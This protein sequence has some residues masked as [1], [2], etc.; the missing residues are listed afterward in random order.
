[1]QKALFIVFLLCAGS[2]PVAAVPPDNASCLECHGDKGMTASG[3]DGKERSLFVDQ[4]AFGKSVH[5]GMSCTDCHADLQSL[6]EYPHQDKLAKADCS[7]CH[8]TVT[9]EYNRSMHAGVVRLGRTNAPSCASCHTAHQITPASD[10]ASPTHKTKLAMLCGTC[11][12]KSSPGPNDVR[13]PEVYAI[14]TNSVHNKAIMSGNLKAASCTD[15]HGS[16]DLQGAGN[17]ESAINHWKIPQTCAKCHPEVG[18]AYQR[19]I[20]GQSFALGIS[21]SPNCTDCHGEH[22]IL[23]R[24]DQDSRIFNLKLRHQI[25]LDCHNSPR[26]LQKF[27]S[28]MGQ[29]MEFS[30]SYHGLSL[31]L[32]SQRAA[33]CTSCHGDH[34]ILPVRNP[35]ST[36]S[37]QQVTKTCGKCHPGASDSFSSSYTHTAAN[38][39]EN[40]L[41]GIVRD[42]YILTIIAVIGG[43]VLHNLLILF[44]Y[45]RQKHR[46]EKNKP[47]LTRFNLQEI[48]QHV[49]LSI[50][51]IGLVI[52]GFML[53]F[54]ESDWFQLLQRAGISEDIR[55]VAHRIFAVILLVTGAWHIWYLV[56][57]QR[58]RQQLRALMFRVDDLRQMVVNIRHHLGLT[59]EKPLFGQY[60]YSEKAEYWALIWGTAVMAVTG[61]VLWF[62]VWFTGL[63]PF[64][65]VK[66]SEIIHYYEAILATLAIIVWHFFFVILHPEEYPMNL[67]WLTGKITLD[68]AEEKYPVWA[69][70]E[71]KKSFT[72]EDD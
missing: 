18:Q 4:V 64:W 49:F 50:S 2:G 47:T 41:A 28:K 6:A 72:E 27:G 10:P 69:H 38:L 13:L 55:S 3:P 36:V 35:L 37:S 54:A 21:E 43:M 30:D 23:G 26:I 48:L 32:G 9:A 71:I 1:M 62:P 63:M 7:S 12:G 15:C 16:H 19:G 51:F 52:T 5:S 24:N 60:D 59:K 39:T 44:F 8:D 42:L 40:K 45:I 61:F 53:K 34:E 11:H 58:G 25:C 31:N 67:S 29:A 57:H 68:L 65:V 70:Q 17:P 33:T 22:G 20:H 14:Y 66:V 56:F 46:H